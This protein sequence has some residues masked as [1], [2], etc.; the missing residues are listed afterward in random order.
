MLRLLRALRGH[1]RGLNLSHLLIR[2]A[3][4]QGVEM[5]DANLS[6]ATLARYL[7]YRDLQISSQRSPQA[8]TGGTGLQQTN[9]GEL[10]VWLEGGQTLYRAW[11]AHT[12]RD[13]TITFSPDGHTLAT[14]GWDGLAKVWDVEQGTLL[15]TGSHPAAVQRVVFSPDGRTLASAGN[16]EVIRFWDAQRGTLLRTLST[17]GGPIFALA[18]HPGGRLLASA[19]SDQQIRLWDM[20]AEQPGETVGL[21]P[22]HT[23]W[24]IRA[25]F[26]PRWAYSGE[27]GFGPVCQAVGRRQSALARYAC[28]AHRHCPRPRLV[29]GSEPP[30]KLR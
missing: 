27:H 24:V 10:R 3:D 8:P 29:S 7:V 14:G 11:Q 26:F 20:Q 16:D 2:G 6:G 9:V 23:N 21:L 1:L 17:P 4:L 12:D 30:G 15:W 25:G 28:R 18:W 5:Q 13:Y 19:G 22:G